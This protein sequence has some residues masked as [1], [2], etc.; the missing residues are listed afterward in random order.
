MAY[1]EHADAPIYGRLVQ[2]RGD[3][4]DDVRRTAE[5][6]WREVERAMAFKQASHWQPFGRGQAQGPGAG[7]AQG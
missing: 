2:E 7:Q 4:P 5:N 1:T 6:V 3:V